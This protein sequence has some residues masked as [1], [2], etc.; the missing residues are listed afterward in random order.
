MTRQ[1]RPDN[2][3]TC[4]ECGCRAHVH[5]HVVPYSLGGTRTLPLCMKCHNKVHHIDERG[6]AIGVLIKA[7]IDRAREHGTKSGRPIGRPRV[8]SR[9]GA[10]ERFIDAVQL[11]WVGASFRGAADS[12]G[13]PRRTLERLAHGELSWD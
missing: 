1:R 11:L 4:F 10:R 9:P 8:M 7:G 12:V 13:V 6:T 2:F 3:P 5:H